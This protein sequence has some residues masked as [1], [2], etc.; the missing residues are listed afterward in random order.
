MRLTSCRAGAA[1]KPD[2]NRNKVVLAFKKAIE[3]TFDEAMWIELG[4]LTDSADAITSHRRLLRSLDWND[5]DYPANVLQMVPRVLGPNHENLRV[6][7]EFVGLEAWLRE[8][9]SSLYEEL[10]SGPGTVTL[11][12]VEGAAEKLG[13]VELMKHAARIRKGIRDDPEQAIG[14]AK[15]LLETVLRTVLSDES[16]KPSEDIPKLLRR[17]QKELELHP[18]DV[19]GKLPGADTIRRTLSNLAQ[20]VVGVAEVR[21]LYGTGHGRLQARELEV[22]HARLVVN[23]AVTLATFLLE[24]SEARR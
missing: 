23:A 20:V 4:Y 11:D 16:Q 10:Y 2:A 13:V 21:T 15:E 5:P 3:A 8:N 17:A 9:D 12:E 24:V 1:M 22:A 14:S 7:E 6:A 18:Q 19:D